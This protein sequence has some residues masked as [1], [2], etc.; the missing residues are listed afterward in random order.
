MIGRS[1]AT[2]IVLAMTAIS[3]RFSPAATRRRRSTR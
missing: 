1:P 2:G 3:A